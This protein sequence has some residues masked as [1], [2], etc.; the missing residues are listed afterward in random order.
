MISSPLPWDQGRLD[1]WAFHP[2]CRG[3][4]PLESLNLV[5]NA[6]GNLS[7]D[8]AL[9]SNER[10]WEHPSVQVGCSGN[11]SLEDI[12]DVW[13]S[14]TDHSQSQQQQSCRQGVV[15]HDNDRSHDQQLHYS[16]AETC[17]IL[18]GP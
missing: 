9:K 13:L 2:F 11:R 7:W 8:N 6:G 4:A 3:N 1:Y 5:G 14:I 10:T 15:V 17:W 18:I 12:A 16:N